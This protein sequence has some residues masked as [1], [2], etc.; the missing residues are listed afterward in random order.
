M[1]GQGTGRSYLSEVAA[2]STL[3]SGLPDGL[4]GSHLA[5]SLTDQQKAPG[6]CVMPSA[7][8]PERPIQKQPWQWVVKCLVP[9][10]MTGERQSC[11]LVVSI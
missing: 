11:G 9:E 7:Q 1:A 4:L 10:Y 3:T 2:R 8:V 6:A 5:V